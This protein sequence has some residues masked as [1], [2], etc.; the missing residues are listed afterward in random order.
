MLADDAPPDDLRGAFPADAGPKTLPLADKLLRE[1]Q[2]L[3]SVILLVA[4]IS[5]AAWYSVFNA[6]K[7]EDLV[8][9]SVKGPGG[10]PLPITKRKKR[11]DGERK[12]GPRFGR[13][14]KNVF[15]YLAAVVFLSYV[16]TGVAMFIHAFWHENP[17][18]WSKDGL[19]WAGE[20]TVVC[21]SPC[22]PPPY[23]PHL[24][25]FHGLGSSYDLILLFERIGP[26]ASLSSPSFPRFH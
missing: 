10:K 13:V 5:L 11:N 12:I 8:Q 18:K 23:F 1:T 2:Y 15:R 14:A 17:Y 19:P 21:P 7:E 20:W 24:P 25:Q 3:Y 4:F 22:L 26:M 16:A 6:K 9:P